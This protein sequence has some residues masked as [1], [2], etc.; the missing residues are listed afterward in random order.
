MK[1][2]IR[3]TESDLIRLI[4]RV[5]DEQYNETEFEPSVDYV[6]ELKTKMDNYKNKMDRFLEDLKSQGNIDKKRFLIQ[7]R[8]QTNQILNQYDENENIGRKDSLSIFKSFTQQQMDM[9]NYFK[10]KLRD[11]SEGNIT[12]GEISE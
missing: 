12:E 9:L 3:L 10:S 6:S 1:K 8:N 7:V 5:I 4:K 2:V 11:S